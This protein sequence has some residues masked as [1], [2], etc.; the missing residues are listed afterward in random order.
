MPAPTMES[1]STRAIVP[2]H[3]LVGLRQADSASPFVAL[4][5]EIEFVDFLLRFGRN[6]AAL[7]EHFGENRF[8]IAPRLQ[9]EGSSRGHGL[10]SVYYQVQNRLLHQIG[11]GAHHER[12]ISV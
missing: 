12:V 6:A 11:I 1:N 3:D 5:G 10:H 4:G 9:S 8:A 7:V 2:L